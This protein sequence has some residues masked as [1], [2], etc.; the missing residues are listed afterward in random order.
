MPERLV[1]DSKKKR[2]R[3]ARKIV[4][5]GKMGIAWIIGSVVIAG[6]ILIAGIAFLILKPQ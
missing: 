2:V 6:I 4:P 5:R 3:P 1:A